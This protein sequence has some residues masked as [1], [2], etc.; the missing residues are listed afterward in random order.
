[1]NSDRGEDGCE[2][3]DQR[4]DRPVNSDERVAGPLN[5]FSKCTPAYIRLHVSVN[6]ARLG[7]F[8]EFM[9]R[10]TMRARVVPDDR[11]RAPRQ[12]DREAR[13]PCKVNGV[14]AGRAPSAHKL[15]GDGRCHETGP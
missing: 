15:R 10:L 1:M 11:Q 14:T 9:F 6:C 3:S 12:I 7:L 8:S 13:G 4:V 5:S 2:T